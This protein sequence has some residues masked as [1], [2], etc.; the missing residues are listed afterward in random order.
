MKP[1]LTSSLPAACNEPSAARLACTFPPT[2]PVAVVCNSSSGI[3]FNSKAR[4]LSSLLRHLPC[5]HSRP[6]PFCLIRQL[7]PRL[8]VSMPIDSGVGLASDHAPSVVVVAL[9]TSILPCQPS[10]AAV[11]PPCK[12]P[13]IDCLAAMIAICSWCLALL[14]F[15]FSDNESATISPSLNSASV[16]IASVRASPGAVPATSV[17]STPVVENESIASDLPL[18]LALTRGASVLPVIVPVP[19]SVPATPATNSPGDKARSSQLRSSALAESS[20]SASNLFWPLLR[21]N[22]A[23]EIE[24]SINS[25]AAET[26]SG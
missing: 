18:N 26:S 19:V 20:P 16:A 2:F 13:S 1:G 9:R 24:S 14:P 7:S 4:A 17:M 21:S 22:R 6:G 11:I 3:C 15:A 12:R 10:N 25:P 5:A 23:S 8:A